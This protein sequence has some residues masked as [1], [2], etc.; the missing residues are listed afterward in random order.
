ML[1]L[2]LATV[3]MTTGRTHHRLYCQIVKISGVVSITYLNV[4]SEAYG[5]IIAPVI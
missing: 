5:L 3:L 1:T 4:F 2:N